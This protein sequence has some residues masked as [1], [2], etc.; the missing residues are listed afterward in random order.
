MIDLDKSDTEVGTRIEPPTQ[1]RTKLFA[2]Y[3][4]RPRR[5]RVSRH[6]VVKLDNAS[7][8]S[9]ANPSEEVLGLVDNTVVGSAKSGILSQRK[10]STFAPTS[11]GKKQFI[12]T[13]TSARR[14]PTRG[15]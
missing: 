8:S 3:L 4:R 14:N 11:S 1:G 9:T 12:P 15:C 2:T 6:P 5:I 13:T 10:A 7:R